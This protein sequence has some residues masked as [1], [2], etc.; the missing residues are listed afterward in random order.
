MTF[1]IYNDMQPKNFNILLNGN[2]ISRVE[3]FTYLGVHI[4]ENLRWDYQAK[5]LIN[6]NK[7][8]VHT[9]AKLRK[10]M[11]YE[12]LS[13][14]YYALFDSSISY[15]IATWGGAYDGVLDGVRSL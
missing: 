15:C 8:L 4:D 3:E 14:L 7:Y 12:T 11:N 6:K 1:S 2:S 5:H 13:M 10:I 9:L